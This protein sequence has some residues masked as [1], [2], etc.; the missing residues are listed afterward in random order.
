MTHKIQLTTNEERLQHSSTPYALRHIKQRH[1]KVIYWLSA[2]SFLAC[3]SL[4]YGTVG[5]P[6]RSKVNKGFTQTA[7]R[8]DSEVVSW[9]TYLLRKEYSRRTAID[10]KRG[11][12]VRVNL[13]IVLHILYLESSRM[14]TPAQRWI[15]TCA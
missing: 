13:L 6:Y 12:H 7:K 14:F 15:T 1:H 8:S 4:K 11:V 9:D 5:V 3:G 2:K 10:T